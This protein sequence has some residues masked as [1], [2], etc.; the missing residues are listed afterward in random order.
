[1]LSGFDWFSMAT[2]L[3]LTF[4]GGFLPLFRP[5]Q[6]KTVR[7]FPSGQAF[8]AGVFLALSL[9]LMLPSSFQLFKAA[10]PEQGYPIASLVAILA[11]LFLLS[12][13][14]VTRHMHEVRGIREGERS[15]AIIPIIMT[16][17]I[18]IPS[19]FLGA[20]LG[21]SSLPAAAFILI[22][23]IAH[24]SSAGFALAI[25]MVRSTLKRTQV[26]ILFTLF[27]CATPIGIL[28]GEEVHRILG[29][30]TMV[31][32]KAFILAMASGVFLYMSSL[33][34]LKNTPLI[35]DCRSRKGFALMICGFVITALVRWLIGEAHHL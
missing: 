21:V 18:A 2:I 6:A 17:M 24:K 13:E 27:A 31:I 1:M 19:F 16:T 35:V 11:F 26:F 9:T 30:H 5:E 3:V 12:I 25:K 7:G 8:A 28:V 32:V 20:A 34:E 14:Q 33:H 22:A 10:F 15:P 29:M 23:I 4:A